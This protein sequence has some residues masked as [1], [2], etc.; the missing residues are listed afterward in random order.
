MTESHTNSWFCFCSQV[1]PLVSSYAKA[2]MYWHS[3]GYDVPTPYKQSELSTTERGCTH[4][5]AESLK[6]KRL[7]DY[8]QTVLRQVLCRKRA[9]I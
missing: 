3:L 9:R 1:Y 8:S 2:T 4:Y 7:L 5:G 6:A